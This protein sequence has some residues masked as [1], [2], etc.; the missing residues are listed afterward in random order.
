MVDIVI[1]KPNDTSSGVL[2]TGLTQAQVDAYALDFAVYTVTNGIVSSTATG[3]TRIVPSA[4]NA[5]LPVLLR[6]VVDTTGGDVIGVAATR[7]RQLPPPPTNV[8]ALAGNASATVQWQ[9]NH[10]GVPTS[11]LVTASNGA[12]MSVTPTSVNASAT[13]TGLTNG[14]SYTFTVQAVNNVGTGRASAASNAVTPTALPSQVL[15]VTR[16]LEFWWSAGQVTSPGNG[17]PLTSLQDFSG[18]GRTF[19]GQGTGSGGTWVS[20]WSNS[21]PA[22]ALNGSNQYYHALASGYYAGMYSDA[23]TVY[24]LHDVQ[25]QPAAIGYVLSAIRPDPLAAIVTRAF[26]LGVKLGAAGNSDEILMDNSGDYYGS[27]SAVAT[28]TDIV[29][30]TPIKAVVTMPGAMR[31]N[32]VAASGLI[33]P[34]LY[35]GAGNQPWT[36]GAM[37]G[38]GFNYYL[39]G[40]VAEVVIFGA[41]H[42]PAEIALMETYLASRA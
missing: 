3:P 26:G 14:V 15:P 12:T 29:W 31:V 24:V 40:R 1:K 33:S 11:Y 16:G 35:A 30:T 32:G 27:A 4:P 18:N 39:Q 6:G 19:A 42:T 10:A 9:G 5:P 22:V 21:K 41:V 36:V 17:N 23:M 13:F 38:G 7:P 28:G 25:A 20:S 8:L 37:Y 34:R 2:K